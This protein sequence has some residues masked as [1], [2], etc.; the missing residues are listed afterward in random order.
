MSM[1]QTKHNTKAAAKNQATEA[2]KIHQILNDQTWK[3]TV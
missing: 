1:R 2:Q 3:F